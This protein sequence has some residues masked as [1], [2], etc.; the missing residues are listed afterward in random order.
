[1]PDSWAFPRTR[2]TRRRLVCLEDR[3][4]NT[5]P[6]SSRSVTKA[7]AFYRRGPRETEVQAQRIV[8][9]LQQRCGSGN[10]D[11]EVL[12]GPAEHINKFLGC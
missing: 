12:L 2:T 9:Q 11:Y 8:W 10:F 7:S 6:R 5:A 3:V 1:M 4:P